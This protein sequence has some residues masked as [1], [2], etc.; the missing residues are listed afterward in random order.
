MASGGARIWQPGGWQTVLIGAFAAGVNWGLY[1]PF[2]SFFIYGDRPA[3]SPVGVTLAALVTGA[4]VGYVGS[5]WVTNEVDKKFLRAAAIEE[6]ASGGNSKSA[7][8]MATATPAEC[9]RIA[10]DDLQKANDETDSK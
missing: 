5:K 6:A 4:L 2:S 7:A 3:S 8:R 10:N 9:L 1:G